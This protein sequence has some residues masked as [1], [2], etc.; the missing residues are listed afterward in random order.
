MNPEQ[1]PSQDPNANVTPQ[2]TEAPQQ[3]PAPETQPAPAEAPA[4][5]SVSPTSPSMSEQP[6]SV[7][8]APSDPSANGQ[9]PTITTVTPEHHSDTLGIVSIVF[10]FFSP[11]IGLILGL[12]GMNKA[13]KAGHDPKLSKI[14]TILSAVF[15]V[16]GTLF[17]ILYIF[18]IAASVSTSS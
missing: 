11:L 13:K 6:I 1:A 18:V 3:P 15:L 10:A 17:L 9:P 8:P 5:E 4:A 2:A 14:G 7:S 12:V 16:F